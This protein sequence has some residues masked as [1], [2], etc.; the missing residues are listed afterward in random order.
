MYIYIYIYIYIHLWIINIC[1]FWI[2]LINCGHGWYL[3]MQFGVYSVMFLYCKHDVLF[4]FYNFVEVHVVQALIE[5]IAKCQSQEIRQR[6]LMTAVWIGKPPFES[7]SG[8]T[9]LLFMGALIWHLKVISSATPQQK[10]TKPSFG[11]N[12]SYS[13]AKQDP[14]WSRL[15]LKY[16]PKRKCSLSSRSLSRL[17]PGSNE[18]P[19][20]RDG[21]KYQCMSC[22]RLFI[23]AIHFSVL[24]YKN[25]V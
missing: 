17:S 24:A 3:S 20:D 11:K 13:Y 4:I 7:R 10:S 21:K 5:T 9:E 8:S 22:I 14:A 12:M 2:G 18:N 19:V 1:M 25:H 23:D 6:H 16:R 15:R